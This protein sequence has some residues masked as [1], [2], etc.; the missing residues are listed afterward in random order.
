M[1]SRSFVQHI[2]ANIF[3]ETL[4]HAQ[5]VKILKSS[6]S[7]TSKPI[8]NLSISFSLYFVLQL[9]ETKALNICCFGS[10]ANSFNT[11]VRLH[12]AAL[13]HAQLSRNPSVRST[14]LSKRI[15]PLHYIFENTI[16]LFANI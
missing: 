11:N 2:C 1:Y 6:T 14:Y 4:Y 3:D 5:Y 8:M 12:W 10:N 16:F 9:C 13:T 7:I 15:F